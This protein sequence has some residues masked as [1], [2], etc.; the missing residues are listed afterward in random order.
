MI[1]WLAVWIIVHQKFYNIQWQTFVRYAGLFIVVAK[2]REA[3]DKH[4]FVGSFEC[5]A[6]TTN[7]EKWQVL[8]FMHLSLL[9][10]IS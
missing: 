10:R 9:Q 2:G 7:N 4:A 6:H 5:S 3:G 1:L 8:I